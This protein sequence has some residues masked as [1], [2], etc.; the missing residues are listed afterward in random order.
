[1]VIIHNITSDWQYLQIDCEI[2]D[3]M[4]VIAPGFSLP[5]I[6][7]R[8]ILLQYIGKVSQ[9]SVNQIMRDH[10]QKF[11]DHRTVL[12]FNIQNLRQES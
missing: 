11:A 2:K 9:A 8:G 12:V 4:D 5:A 10:F 7:I 6:I 3:E 1:M